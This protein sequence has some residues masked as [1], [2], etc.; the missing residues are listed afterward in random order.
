MKLHPQQGAGYSLMIA[1]VAE[2]AAYGVWQYSMLF[3]K[4]GSGLE[5]ISKS[6]PAQYTRMKVEI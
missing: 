3:C 6:L 4:E 1:Y 2:G 5:T